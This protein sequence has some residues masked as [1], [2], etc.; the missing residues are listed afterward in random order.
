MSRSV[1]TARSE[2]FQQPRPL[3]RI[4]GGLTVDLCS[5]KNLY[6]ACGTFS[7]P[8]SSLPAALNNKATSYEIC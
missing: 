4:T 8:K 6:G 5:E 7:S 1:K 3:H 2:R